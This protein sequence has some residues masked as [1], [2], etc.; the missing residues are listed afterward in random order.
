LSWRSATVWHVYTFDPGIH[1]SGP[2][3]IQASDWSGNTITSPVQL[4]HD[5]TP[6]VLPLW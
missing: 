4:P 1:F 3:I 6:P 5:I 2:V